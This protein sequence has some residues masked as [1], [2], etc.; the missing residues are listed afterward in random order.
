MLIDKEKCVSGRVKEFF[1]LCIL[2]NVQIYLIHEKVFKTYIAKYLSTLPHLSVTWLCQ[3]PTS[4]HSPLLWKWMVEKIISAHKKG[5]DF[6]SNLITTWFYLSDSISPGTFSL[7]QLKIGQ[8]LQSTLTNAHIK[9]QK[10]VLRALKCFLIPERLFFEMNFT[11][12]LTKK[13][14]PEIAQK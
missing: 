10:H 8:S 6:T 9:C 11:N 7:F 4:T 3:Q 5:I 12:R 2:Q 1:R 14:W 13:H